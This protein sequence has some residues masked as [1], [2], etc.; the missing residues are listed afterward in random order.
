MQWAITVDIHFSDAMNAVVDMIRR[1]IVRRSTLS[2]MGYVMSERL[3]G[4]GRFLMMLFIAGFMKTAVTTKRPAD[5]GFIG[6]NCA[7]MRNSCLWR[8]CPLLSG[9]P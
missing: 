6:G 5:F 7:P 9:D 8:T 2:L 1:H 4:T 3:Y